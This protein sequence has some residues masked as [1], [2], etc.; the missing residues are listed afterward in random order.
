MGLE[1]LN[2]NLLEIKV[3]LVFRYSNKIDLFF[4]GIYEEIMK[5]DVLLLF[6]FYYYNI[7]S[8]FIFV[9]LSD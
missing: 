8:L 1:V 7:C 2:E 3:E 4:C 6:Y 5:Y 9:C